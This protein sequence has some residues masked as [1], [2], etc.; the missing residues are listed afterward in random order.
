[1]PECLLDNTEYKMTTGGF[2]RLIW[3]VFSRNPGFSNWLIVDRRNHIEFRLTVEEQEARSI[4]AEHSG[5]MMLSP[6][7]SN[8]SFQQKKD[9]ETTVIADIVEA[10]VA[11]RNGDQEKWKMLCSLDHLGFVEYASKT[12]GPGYVPWT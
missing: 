2:W 8:L 7:F 12:C 3:P 10:L 5:A 6:E 4:F 1:M 9:Q 11:A